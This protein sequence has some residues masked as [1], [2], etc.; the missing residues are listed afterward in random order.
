MWAPRVITHQFDIVFL[1]IGIQID[2]LAD[3]SVRVPC[4]IC[5]NQVAQMLTNVKQ[6]YLEFGG[7]MTGE[8]LMH[9]SRTQCCLTEHIH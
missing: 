7:L 3:F 1:K 4:F 5:N 2:A 9:L 6:T 8:L